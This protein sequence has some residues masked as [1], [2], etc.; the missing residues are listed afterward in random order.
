[1]EIGLGGFFY[2][3]GSLGF[4]KSTRMLT[5]SDGSKVSHDVLTVGG[6][7]L[8]AFAGVN[9]GSADAVGFAL[10][11]VDFGLVIASERSASDAIPTSKPT[12][13]ALE[14]KAGSA[15][16]VGLP[17]G[18]TMEVHDVAVG[19]NLAD[20]VTGRVMDFSAMNF[21]VVTGTGTTHLM[22]MKG[23]NGQQIQVAADFTLNLDGYVY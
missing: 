12:R 2:A 17:D 6:Q 14:A 7:D 10:S 15:S 13:V 8:Q 18:F 22:A 21:A 9:A 1:V 3:S 19:I 16:L 20:S 23:A 4:E 11:G 5:L